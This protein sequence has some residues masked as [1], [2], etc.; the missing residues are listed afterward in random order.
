MCTSCI[1]GRGVCETV[2]GIPRLDN[3]LLMG[4]PIEACY[5][6]I[7]YNYTIFIILDFNE[8]I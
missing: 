8:R 2:S 3:R 6:L 4:Y 7:L 1:N 5:V